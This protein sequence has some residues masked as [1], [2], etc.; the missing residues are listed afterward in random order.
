MRYVLLALVVLGGCQKVDPL[1]CAK[2]M[3]LDDPRCAG[4]NGD[5]G[6]GG[7][8]VT[9]GGTVTGLTGAGLVLQVNGGDDKPIVSDGA[10][11]FPT[12]IAKDASYLVTVLT[13]PTNPSEMCTLSNDTGTASADIDNVI[14]TCAPLAYKVGGSASG[15][16][17]AVMLQNNGGEIINVSTNGPFVFQNAVQSG[18]MYS[19]QTTGTVPTGCRVSGNTGVVGNADVK[20]VVLNCDATRVTVG[21]T[22]TGLNGTLVLKNMSNNDTVTINQTGTS[23]YAFPMTI[24]KTTGSYNVTVMTNP[25]YPPEAQTCTV[26]NGMGGPGVAGPIENVDVNCIAKQFSVGG[27]ATGVTG[28]VVLQNNGADNLSL[29]AN[30][31]FTF[32]TKIAS[33]QSYAVS[34]FQ[35]PAT[36]GCTVSNGTGS[37]GGANVTNVG[38]AC[39]YK[40]PGIACGASAFCT[41]GTMECCDP[42]G[43][44]SCTAAGSC[45]VFA[46]PCDSRADCG[47]NQVCCAFENGGHNHI[48][49]VSCSSSSSCGSND[50]LCDPKAASPCSSG[51]CKAFGLLPGFYS[52]Q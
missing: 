37:V 39:S 14:V 15:V 5:G 16:T 41:A 28:T 33:A 51:T 17:V 45:G 26:T 19:V 36:L 52:C 42:Y 47:S 48:N 18:M 22:V 7:E 6:V 13:Q 20:S 8:T 30:G 24:D 27:N 43:T 38:I 44:P 34:V 49:S 10:F 11:S 25:V 12:P 3:N 32:A 46:M 23:T 35:T 50:R 1:F 2:D 9:I 21:G 31:G 29:T 4:G 40:D